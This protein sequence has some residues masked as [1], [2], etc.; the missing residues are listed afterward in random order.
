MRHYWFLLLLWAILLVVHSNAD[1]PDCGNSSLPAQDKPTEILDE[2]C[3]SSGYFWSVSNATRWD[4]WFYYFDTMSNLNHSEHAQ[5]FF[6]KIGFNTAPFVSVSGVWVAY[7][8]SIPPYPDQPYPS[9]KI[10]KITSLGSIQIFYYLYNN[11]SI[12]IGNDIVLKREPGQNSE[13]WMNFTTPD[14]VL[15]TVVYL[16]IIDA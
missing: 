4:K 15:N 14:I 2:F 3:D 12:K 8:N 7:H 1:V 9:I 11:A 10:S 6:P 16:H 5:E 13:T